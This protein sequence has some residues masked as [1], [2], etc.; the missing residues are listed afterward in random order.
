MKYFRL[1]PSPDDM[2]C[3]PQAEELLKPYSYGAPNSIWNALTNNQL[4][5][6]LVP[7]GIPLKNKA[8]WTDLLTVS[9]IHSPFLVVSK[10]MLA[11]FESIRLPEYFSYPVSVMKRDKVQEYYIF[12]AP[13][14][15]IRYINLDTCEAHIITQQEF[16]PP[17][18]ILVEPVEIRSEAIFDR[19]E[20]D[21]KPPRYLRIVRYELNPEV[22]EFDMFLIPGCVGQTHGYIVSEKLVDA[23]N[24]AGLTGV[25]FGPLEP[26][27]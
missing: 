5:D 10:K 15:F 4:T 22:I 16:F 23:V 8:K 26:N 11:V 27:P 6:L 14:R 21:I 25:T 17:V 2:G 19:F 20:R 24:S 7:Q 13:K 1:Y 18:T 9:P 12:I 3:A